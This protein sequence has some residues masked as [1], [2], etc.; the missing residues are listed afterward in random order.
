MACLYWYSLIFGNLMN[1]TR[2]FQM[3]HRSALNA[4]RDHSV[5]FPIL[6]SVS[7]EAD[8]KRAKSFKTGVENCMCAVESDHGQSCWIR[9]SYL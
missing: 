7:R 1:Q 9:G 2:A 4:P 5:E 3:H 8:V 6:V